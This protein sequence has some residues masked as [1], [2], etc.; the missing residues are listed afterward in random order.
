[1]DASL[2]PQLWISW[3]PVGKEVLA[4]KI[5]M[6]WIPRG[7]ECLRPQLYGTILP[8]SKH[9]E[10]VSVDTKRQVAETAEA[11]A[12]SQRQVCSTSRIAADTRRTITSSAIDWTSAKLLRRVA[13]RNTAS[14][15]TR[16]CVGGI[17]VC[18]R[19][20]T[21]RTLSP[22]YCIVRGATGREVV[23]RETV[24]CDTKRTPGMGN[25]VAAKTRRKL[26]RGNVAKAAL[27]RTVVTRVR[28]RFDT[29]LRIPHVLEYVKTS[30]G[31][32]SKRAVA[33]IADNFRARGIRSFAV[34][35]GEMTLSDTFQ[36]ETVQPLAIGDAVR[37]Q[38][39]DYRFS[40]LVEETLQ[41]DLLQTVKGAYSKDATLYSAIRIFVKEAKASYY[42]QS[43]AAALGLQLHWACDDFTPS[44]NFE[45][46]GMTYQDFISALFGWTAKLPQRQ[47]N[48]FIREDTL[49]IVQRGKEESVLDITD[50]PHGRPTVERRLVR[51]LW[52]S[53]HASE[54]AGNAYNEEDTE[55]VP[56]TGT[57]SWEEMS[58]TYHNGFLTSETNEKGMTRYTYHGE[59]LTSKQTHNKDGST[60]RT[61]YTYAETERDVYLVKEWERTTE[62]IN[63]GKKHTEY[64]WTD[65]NNERGTERITY[66]APLGYG[67]YATTVYVDGNLEGSTLSQG[68]PGG[69]ASRFTVEQSNLSLGSRYS[70][71]DDDAPFTS[72]I[73]TEFPVKGE[74]YLK[75]LT[76]AIL[77][78]NRKTQ[79]IVT[80]EVY[81]N[82]QDGVPDVGHI[83]D[84]T[85]RI[86]FE[87]QEYFLQSNAVELTPRSLKQTIKMT[88]WY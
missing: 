23:K 70:G 4:P 56:F 48:V 71:D 66:H 41:R 87:G 43:I 12:D 19:C 85:E 62:P 80:L 54:T 74:A 18:I 61:E 63:D 57:I 82:I 6:T 42:A 1:M 26:G 24:R 30:R 14:A 86:K 44:Q 68:K 73:D 16:R 8:A 75:E 47:V 50:W 20:D 27:R 39:L 2:K 10:T 83:A 67:W 32:R 40:F 72:L 7:I 5:Y 52:H 13:Q 69:K 77:W 33:Q 9:R 88:R 53:G 36:M 17:Y 78:L 49:H 58:R 28:V 76:Q 21:Y 65:W 29:L 38:L 60:A 45:D 51:S 64:D 3:I 81:A 15:A 59:Y 46:S 31:R 35:L 11:R 25:R 22:N 37:G 84:F 55:P 79:E 34:T